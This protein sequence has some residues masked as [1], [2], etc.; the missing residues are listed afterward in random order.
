MNSR[1]VRRSSWEQKLNTFSQSR[2]MTRYG[3]NTPLKIKRTGKVIKIESKNALRGLKFDTE[4]AKPYYFRKP[5][6]NRPF[7]L[8]CGPSCVLC[9]KYGK[10]FW[11]ILTRNC[12]MRRLH[13]LERGKTAIP[14]LLDNY[15]ATMM[16]W[17]WG[18]A[19]QSAWIHWQIG[20]FHRSIWNSHQKYS[21]M[22]ERR[23]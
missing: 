15:Q 14:E 4:I 19:P 22:I 17:D 20:W 23:D 16:H 21:D 13:K 8:V 7:T 2:L 12:L 6:P 5:R 3:Y 9:Q 18:T 1:L 10:R 11:P